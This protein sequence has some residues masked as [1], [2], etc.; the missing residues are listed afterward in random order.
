MRMQ[1]KVI[2]GG[3][4][5]AVLL[6]GACV[7]AGEG[8]TPQSS[9]P[10]GPFGYRCGWSRSA[11]VERFGGSQATEA[12]VEAALAWL[13]RHQDRNG[14]WFPVVKGRRRKTGRLGISGLATLA[15]LSAGYTHKHGKYRDNVS[16]GLKWILSHQKENGG[17]LE[18]KGKRILTTDGY[19]H[20]M[21]ALAVVEAYGM[22]QDKELKNLAQKAV[23]YATR[24][25]QKPG[26]GWRYKPGQEGDLSITSWF[27]HMLVNAKKARL[28]VDAGGFQGGMALLNKL[29]SNRLGRAVYSTSNAGG[30]H[31][32]N[33][34][35]TFD[36]RTAMSMASRMRMGVVHTDAVIQLGAR[37]LQLADPDWAKLDVYGWYYGSSACIQVGGK[38]WRGFNDK[39]KKALLPNQR[40]GG[41]K[42]GSAKDVDGSWDPEGDPYGKSSG[43]IFTTVLA[44]MTLE[45]YYRDHVR[46][47]SRPLEHKPK[48]KPK[49]KPQLTPEPPVEVDPDVNF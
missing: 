32:N 33:K 41:P 27:V 39:M 21:A 4:A 17:I 3:I 1:N 11:A 10:K 24:V 34:V 25:H 12:A 6:S 31:Y 48:P 14:G 49:N 15:F 46:R 7:L 42:D 9:A 45:V 18:S 22:T 5:I 23:H 35:K 19:N 37:R 30:L 16:K 47:D 28:S 13:A 26:S 38:V 36:G 44:T 43:R 29:T 20:P 8:N 40:K 2:C